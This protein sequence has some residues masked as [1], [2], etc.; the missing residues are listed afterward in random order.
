MKKTLIACFLLL[1]LLLGAAPARGPL[2]QEDPGRY[3]IEES[4]PRAENLTRRCSLSADLT[5]TAYTWRLTDEELS[6]TQV[7]QAGQ[8]V[9]LSWGDSVPVKAVRLAFKD[10]PGAYRI[11][12]FDA[13]GTLLK[14]ETAPRYINHAVFVEE[15]TRTVTVVPEEQINLCSLYAYGEGVIPDYHPWAPTPEKL[16]Y[17]IV[18]MHPDDDVLFMGAILPLYTVEQGRE[19]TIFYAATRERVRKDEAE[20]G[21]W[22]MGL[23]KAPILGTF[24]D[25]PPSYYEKY[26]NTFPKKEVVDC[27]VALFRQ[28][29]PEVVFSHDLEGEYGHWQHILLAHAV[30]EAV[31]LAADPAYEPVSAEQYG[32]WQVKKLYLHLYPENPIELPATKAIAAY[33]GLTPVEI[34][35]AAFQCHHSQ[36]PSRHAVTNEGVYSL[37]SFGLAYTAVGADTPGVNDPFEHIDPSSLHGG[38]TAAP[39][40]EAPLAPTQTPTPAPTPVIAEETALPGTTAPAE[41]PTAE[42]MQDVSEGTE[43]PSLWSSTAGADR[44]ATPAPSQTPTR[45]E[46]DQ[47]DGGLPLFWVLLGLVLLA[48]IILIGLSFLTK[49]W[50]VRLLL[51]A[52]ALILCLGGAWMLLRNHQTLSEPEPV[53]ALAFST[54]TLPEPEALSGYLALEALDLSACEQVDAALFERIRQAVPSGCRILWRVPLTDGRFPSDSRALT[55]P[56]FSGADVPLL[57]YFPQLEALDASGS[58]AY[59]A[60]LTLGTSAPELALTFTLPVGDKILT[61][62]DETLV[63]Q[64]TPNL[65]LLQ[66]MLPAFPKLKALDLSQAPVAPD[67]A[68]SLMEQFPDLAVTYAVPLGSA[69]LPPDSERIALGDAGIRGVEDLLTALPYLPQL[70]SVDLHGTELTLADLL[71]IL[72]AWPHLALSQRVTLLDAAVETDAKELDLREA[73]CPPDQL[74]PLLRPFFALERVYLPQEGDWEAALPDLSAA[75]PETRFVCRVTAFGQTVENTLEELDI[76][77]MPLAAP[78]EVISAVD[79]LPDLQKLIMC[80]CGLTNA[81][82]EELVRL[83]PQ[84]KFVWN[85]HLG[86]HTLRTDTL[87][88]STKNPSK[89]TQSYYSDSMNRRIKNTKRLNEGDI[90]ALKYCTDLMALDLGHNYLTAKDLEVFQYLPHLQVLILA[91]NKITD[92]S[93]LAQLKEL[94]Y[95]ELFMNRIP[96]MSPLVGLPNL[97]DINIANT[98]LE[99]I[100]PL[101]RFTQAKRLWFSMNGLTSEQNKAVVEALPNCLCNYTTNNETGEGWREGERYQW[102]RELF[103]YGQ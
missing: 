47:A 39:T 89:Y 73:V 50:P 33:G 77:K 61:M 52:L 74:L 62:E 82:M 93:A 68:L 24:P 80:D 7:L 70:K 95:V 10:Y 46:D 15:G 11:Q 88:F 48:A 78:E 103:Q 44:E 55:L 41:E 32:S 64:A 5:S 79:K 86:P 63:V 85:I 60:L 16:D 83:R 23:R 53:R 6:T 37:S 2:A 56:H 36:L 22:I 34:A 18:A 12:Q 9:S 19:G 40:E 69:A 27:L 14:E 4:G 72:D 76:S 51:W 84:V 3:S 71:S 90:E 1:A 17:L 81:Q 102:I 98:H 20:N 94:E 58:D 21:A 92:I 99:D 57:T 101:K 25:I 31:P 91:D 38:P 30:R 45:A 97:A 59:D 35:A 29:R 13:A 42:P 65:D 67:Q 75:H 43:E 8:R 49:G 100:E 66:R 54:E 26:K 28:Y 87:A 96:D